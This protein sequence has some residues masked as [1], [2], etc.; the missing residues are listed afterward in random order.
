MPWSSDKKCSAIY[1]AELKR[2]LYFS[3]ICL[4]SFPLENLKLILNHHGV[5]LSQI[6]KSHTG[7]HQ[8]QGQALQELK[9]V[10]EHNSMPLLQT[11]TEAQIDRCFGGPDSWYSS[12]IHCSLCSHTP[13]HAV[14]DGAAWWT[15]DIGW[16]LWAYCRSSGLSRVHSPVTISAVSEANVAAQQIPIVNSLEYPV[17]ECAILQMF[18]CISG[19]VCWTSIWL[20][21]HFQSPS[22]SWTPVDGCCWKMC[23]ASKT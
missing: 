19:S 6:I 7:I 11:Q 3:Q 12:S 9:F 20:A 5:P 22:S 1:F 2:S 16:S 8:T 21:T 23:V 15:K 17:L 10:Q 14:K 13:H 18:G 4:S